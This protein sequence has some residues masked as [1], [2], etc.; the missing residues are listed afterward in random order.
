M[1]LPLSVKTPP[2]RGPATEAIP[3]IAPMNPVYIGRF[4]KGTEYATMIKAPLRIPA[5]PKPAIARPR[6]NAIE[7]GAIPHTKLPSSKIPIAV[8]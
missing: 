6:I 5:E 3:Y 2:R 8:R 7:F 4:A 1:V